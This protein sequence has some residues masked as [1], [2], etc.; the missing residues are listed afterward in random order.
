[1][2]LF[3]VCSLQSLDGVG[4]VHHSR[5]VRL[6]CAALGG[7][8][9]A[10]EQHREEWDYMLSRLQGAVDIIAF[11][12]G[13]P[14]YE[15]LETFQRINVELCAKYGFEC[16]SNIESFDRDIRNPKFQVINWEK[17]RFKMRSAENAGCTKFITFEFTP[18]MSPNGCYPAAKYLLKRY[19]EENGINNITL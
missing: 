4:L 1:M 2:P 18:F 10:F 9:V 12:D 13:H 14:D 16:W 11:Q 19:L 3:Y 15:D 6:G 8:D 7:I 17:M 5:L